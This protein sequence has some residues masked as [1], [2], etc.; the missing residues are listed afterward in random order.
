MCCG[1]ILIISSFFNV[2]FLQNETFSLQ[3]LF[4]TPEDAYVSES[5][6]DLFSIF[7]KLPFSRLFSRLL[8]Y[9]IILRNCVSLE[10][11]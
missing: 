6:S 10:R 2:K 5:A 9:Y 1:K 7:F 8:D 3:V 4:E 11:N